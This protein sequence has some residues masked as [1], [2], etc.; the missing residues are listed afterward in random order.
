M[1]KLEWLMNY[2]NKK[3]EELAKE[4]LQD[5]SVVEKAFLRANAVLIKYDQELA[6]L[7]SNEYVDI[8]NSKI[9]NY[10]A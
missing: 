2:M 5:F 6:L 7:Y 4:P 3:L 8:T 1:E 10:L 9:E